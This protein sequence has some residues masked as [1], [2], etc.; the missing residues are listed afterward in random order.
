MGLSRNALAKGFQA[1]FSLNYYSPNDSFYKDT[2]GKGNFMFGGSLS[3]KTKI[4]LEFRAE[5]NYFR[6]KG[7]MTVTKE[8]I[9]FTIVPIVLGLRFK[10]IDKNLSPY[11]GAGID[12]YSY[13]EKYPERFEDVS[14][15]TTGFHAE[16][17]SYMNI[18]PRIHLDLN[19]RYIKADA[20]SFDEKIKLG[21]LKAGIG[22]GY[23][24]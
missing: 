19:V 2:Y 1:G 13:K 20:E 23:S 24:F 14:E 9:K 11:L 10:I 22:I 6:D 12:F 15:S 7:E 16:I 3:Y 18:T 21:G 4:R 8:E 5:V 17:G